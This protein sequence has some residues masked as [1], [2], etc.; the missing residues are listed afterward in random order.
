MNDKCYCKSGRKET[1]WQEVRS[2]ECLQIERDA[3]SK[4]MRVGLDRLK[5]TK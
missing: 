3:F 2:P 5:R 4:A 1:G